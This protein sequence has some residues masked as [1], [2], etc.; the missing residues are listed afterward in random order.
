MYQNVKRKCRAIVFA[1][2]CG[3]LV[4]QAPYSQFKMVDVEIVLNYK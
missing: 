1:H 3:V 2:F 4:V